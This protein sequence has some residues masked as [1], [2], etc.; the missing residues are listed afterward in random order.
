M[1]GPGPMMRSILVLAGAAAL[2]ACGQ[3]ESRHDAA[4]L[5]DV[6]GDLRSR[7]EEIRRTLSDQADAMQVELDRARLAIE[8]ILE[9]RPG[10]SQEAARLVRGRA[11]QILEQ[12][13]ELLRRVGLNRGGSAGDWARALQDEMTRLERSLDELA[14]RSGREHAGS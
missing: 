14:M 10:A 5:E 6:A 3:T 2:L 1:T 12:G 8:K 11:E 4:A 13:S 7:G 9:G